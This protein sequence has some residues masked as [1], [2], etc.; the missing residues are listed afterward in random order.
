MENNDL[1]APPTEEELKELGID[2]PKAIP[3]SK[4]LFT[5]PTE[6]ELK[7]IV[8]MPSR[9]PLLTET[10]V[11]P[12]GLADVLKAQATSLDVAGIPSRIASGVAAVREQISEGLGEEGRIPGPTTLGEAYNKF[13]EGW[14]R[15]KEDLRNKAPGAADIT[16]AVEMFI[17]TPMSGIKAVTLLGKLALGAGRTATVEGIERLLQRLKGEESPDL[18]TIPGMVQAGVEAIPLLKGV[19]RGVAKLPGKITGAPIEAVEKYLKHPKVLKDP[20]LNM[21]NIHERALKDVKT[22]ES[23]IAR[24][25]EGIQARAWDIA[26]TS[27]KVEKTNEALKSSIANLKDTISRQAVPN[28]AVAAVEK[29][30]KSQKDLIYKLNTDQMGM[31]KNS[32]SKVSL[33]PIR[34]VLEG[35]KREVGLKE[36]T[37]DTP[38]I[39]DINIALNYLNQLDEIEPPLELIKLRRT[40][41]NMA[42]ATPTPGYVPPDIVSLRMARAKI[43]EVLDSVPDLGDAFKKSRGAL[44]EA[45]KSQD[46]V[47]EVFK[48]DDILSKL[49]GVTSR[50]GY[51]IVNAITKLEEATGKPIS[52]QLKEYIKAK[53]ISKFPKQM[54]NEIQKLPEYPSATQAKNLLNSLKSMQKTE[55]LRL[56]KLKADYHK[57][58]VTSDN[59]QKL[60]EKSFPGL[61]VDIEDMKKLHAYLEKDPELMEQ[62]RLLG[63]KTSLDAGGSTVLRK[64][65]SIIGAFK[66][67]AAGGRTGAAAG[68]SLGKILKSRFTTAPL[69]L[70]LALEKA[71]EATLGKLTNLINSGKISTLGTNEIMNF[72][73]REERNEK[74]QD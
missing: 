60:V 68:E 20:N 45:V 37:I 16:D 18:M 73:R 26:E 42:Y 47:L 55:Q 59:L 63:L 15:Y 66:G 7:S 30:M 25:E 71:S 41:D 33:K 72:L 10:D 23:D 62:V 27:S 69:D 58:G 74:Y 8:S 2:T 46:K 31:V 14:K 64:L 38:E 48:N 5:P 22:M 13:F 54:K 29:A 3:T 39:K 28:E 53:D 70:Q 19:T 36:G 61:H 34:E 6:E 9:I 56:S 65:G 67:G 24:M 4:D 51:K 32:T 49:M 21:G 40:L 35:R 50:S 44:A 43:N 17:P 57:M 11:K 52:N 1:F 12:P